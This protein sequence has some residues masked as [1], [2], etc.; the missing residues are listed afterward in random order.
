MEPVIFTCSQNFL[1]SYFSSDA[2]SVQPGVHFTSDNFGTASTGN[3]GTAS[4]QNSATSIFGGA[5]AGIFLLANPSLPRIQ[6]PYGEMKF[7]V[8]DDSVATV[9]LCV[10][11]LTRA[12]SAV[13]T[14]EDGDAAVELVMAVA[15][16]TEVGDVTNFQETD[17]FDV[18]LMDIYMSRLNGLDAIR[19]I[20]SGLQEI[21]AVPFNNQSQS[22]TT[23]VCAQPIIIAMS[24]RINEELRRSS[25]EAGADAV[26][27]KPFFIDDLSAVIHPHWA[28]LQRARRSMN[29]NNSST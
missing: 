11:M 19:Q 23:A 26:I 15:T 2:E 17:L 24:I 10:Q 27:G 1:H 6:L 25:L 5:N 14:A 12:G 16:N 9:R 8:V 3:V 28:R 18:V 7:L 20:R 21:R 22:S 29:P 13:R 4:T